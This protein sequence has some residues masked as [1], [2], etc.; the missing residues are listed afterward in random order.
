MEVALETHYYFPL[1]ILSRSI[2]HMFDAFIGLVFLF[3]YVI[4]C[5]GDFKREGAGRGNW[6]TQADELAQ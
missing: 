1:Y 2:S 6:G 4:M 3:I 5:R